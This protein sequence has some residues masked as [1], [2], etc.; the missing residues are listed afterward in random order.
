MQQAEVRG[1]PLHRMGRPP[2]RRDIQPLCQRE[3][4]I[5]ARQ[6]AGR[7]RCE[8]IA[9]AAMHRTAA[10]QRSPKF[11][12]MRSPSPSRLLGTDDLAT[13]KVPPDTHMAQR[14]MEKILSIALVS[15]VFRK[16]S[17]FDIFPPVMMAL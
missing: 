7:F 1:H 11:R 6:H 16:N 8:D 2:L 5:Q 3:V 9:G 13:Q 17:L 10:A 15:Q 4:H 14:A 12:N